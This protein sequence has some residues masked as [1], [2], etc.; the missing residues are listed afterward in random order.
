MKRILALTALTAGLAL[1]VAA[2][3]TAGAGGDL[4][5]QHAPGA[6]P[7]VTPSPSPAAAPAATTVAAPVEAVTL[8]VEDG[9][10]TTGP[11]EAIVAVAPVADED[12]YG[13]ELHAQ[14]C[15]SRQIFC[16]VDQSGRYLTA[17]PVG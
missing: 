12:A 14:L 5:L 2:S 6:P 7:V 4:S 17:T 10:V 9:H 13:A 1:A 8:P 3:G 16:E 11:A 15:A